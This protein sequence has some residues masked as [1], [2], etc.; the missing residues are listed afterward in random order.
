MLHDL[1]F[2]MTWYNVI[3][4]IPKERRNPMIKVF[5]ILQ[6]TQQFWHLSDQFQQIC[7]ISAFYKWFGN[8]AE[9][10][11]I[12]KTHSVSHLL[13]TSDLQPLALLNYIYKLPGLHQRSKGTGIQPGCSPA[14]YP[15][16][17]L[18]LLQIYLIHICNF[19][20]AARR[21]FNVFCNLYN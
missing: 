17:Q 9:L 16:F 5:C 20:L 14:Q 12:N 2:R 15:H 11:L 8:G 18:A 4:T 7:A 19:I 1:V 3:A 6:K 21:W 13:N 10:R